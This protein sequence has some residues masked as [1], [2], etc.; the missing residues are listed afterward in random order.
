[1]TKSERIELL[2]DAQNKLIDAIALITEA[3]EGAYY[4]SNVEAYFLAALKGLA[5]EGIGNLDISSIIE[6]VKE[7]GK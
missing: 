3:I 4:Q 1:M 5:Y 2:E 7:E 6:M